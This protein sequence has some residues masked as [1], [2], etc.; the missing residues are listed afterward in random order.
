[1]E[2]LPAASAR[3]E[4]TKPQGNKPVRTPAESAAA[5]ARD[6]SKVDSTPE[7]IH[8]GLFLAALRRHLIQPVAARPCINSNVP[9]SRANHA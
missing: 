6:R 5:G 7:E 4:Q 1:M 9:A 8:A 3:N 2:P